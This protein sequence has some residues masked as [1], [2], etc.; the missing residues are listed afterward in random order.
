M[1]GG[2]GQIIT[3]RARPK[4][5][6]QAGVVGVKPALART[7]ISPAEC[8]PLC[9]LLMPP[10]QIPITAAEHHLRYRPRYKLQDHYR[11]SVLGALGRVSALAVFSVCWG[12]MFACFC[13]VKN[14]LRCWSCLRSSSSCLLLFSISAC[15]FLFSWGGE[16]GMSFAMEYLWEALGGL[17]LLWSQGRSTVTFVTFEHYGCCHS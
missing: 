7:F 6:L 3:T 1:S 10:V 16:N 2:G 17:H 14:T 13:W 15:F 9:P 5:L 8:T 12:C 4:E 11:D